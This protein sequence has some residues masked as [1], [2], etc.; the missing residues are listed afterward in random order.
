M[1]ERVR[2]SVLYSEKTKGKDDYD[3][4]DYEEDTNR[5]TI[6]AE[7]LEEEQANI[8]PDFN[9][10]F[11]TRSSTQVYNVLQTNVQNHTVCNVIVHNMSNIAYYLLQ[12]QSQ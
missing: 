5:Y 8:Q 12:K 11:T 2:I 9:M 10:A 4:S 1:E 3:N 6:Q 7:Y